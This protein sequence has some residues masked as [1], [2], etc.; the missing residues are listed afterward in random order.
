LITKRIFPVIEIDAPRKNYLSERNKV[1]DELFLV[2]NVDEALKLKEDSIKR[3]TLLWG[4]WL[5][6]FKCPKY[7]YTKGTGDGVLTTGQTK[8]V[9][10]QARLMGANVTYW[11]GEGEV[12]LLHNFWDIMKYQKEKNLPSVLFTNGSIFHDDKITRGV[13]D[14]DSDRLI[15]QLNSEYSGMHFYI[16]YWSSNPTNAANMVGVQ[17]NEYP[18]ETI[19][20]N[21]IPLSLAKLLEKVDKRR[22]G[23]EVMVSQENYDDVINNILPTIN[24]LDIYGYIEPMLFSGNATSHLSALALNSSQNTSLAEIFA[25]GGNYCEKRQSIE[26]IVKGAKLTP[27]IAIPPRDEDS[28]ID[29]NGNVIDLFSSFHNAYFRDMREKSRKFG[30]CLCRRYTENQIIQEST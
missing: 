4:P 17:P 1:I 27:G 28:I 12:T 22:L 3:L 9:I 16:K 19:N 18:Y 5:C 21:R 26:L 13:L 7:C 29:A 25:S 6:N 10:E 15:D 24:D 11:P 30:G 14:I 23:V 20:G 2:G 8:E